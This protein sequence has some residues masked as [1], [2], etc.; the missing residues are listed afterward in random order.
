MDLGGYF[1]FGGGVPR[2][3]DPVDEALQECIGL[4]NSIGLREQFAEALQRFG[5]RHCATGGN[6]RTRRGHGVDFCGLGVDPRNLSLKLRQAREKRGRR[7]PVRDHPH[8]IVD[9][10]LRPRPATRKR[11]DPILGGGAGEACPCLRQ[12][13]VENALEVG[14]KQQSNSGLIDWQ[15]RA[16]IIQALDHDCILVPM[17]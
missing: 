12:G 16:R 11:G 14:C 9:L 17:P 13:L 3:D 8:D 15:N 10:S 5:E 1:V 6:Q 2:D 7:V 4:D